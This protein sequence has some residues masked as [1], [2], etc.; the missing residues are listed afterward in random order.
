MAR[1]RSRAMDVTSAIQAL[2][3]LLLVQYLLTRR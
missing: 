3:I 1:E 2:I